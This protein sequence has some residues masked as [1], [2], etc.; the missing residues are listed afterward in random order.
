[1]FNTVILAAGWMSGHS[2]S[3]FKRHHGTLPVGK[4]GNVLD[5]IL[6]KPNFWTV[7]PNCHSVMKINSGLTGKPLWKCSKLNSLTR[8]SYFPCT[9]S[10]TAWAILPCTR[11]QHNFKV[12]AAS[13]QKINS[14]KNT[15]NCQWEWPNNEKRTVWPCWSLCSWYRVQSHKQCFPSAPFPLLPPSLCLCVGWSPRRWPMWTEL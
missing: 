10:L 7:Q 6:E 3:L 4:P 13:R 11:R 5:R 1:M 15:Q 8:L 9:T 14:E 2:L 12:L